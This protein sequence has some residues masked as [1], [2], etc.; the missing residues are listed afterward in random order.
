[1]SCFSAS[2]P[3]S[4]SRIGRWLGLASLAAMALGSASVSAQTLVTWNGGGADGNWSTTG[5]WADGIAP[6]T[7]G[8]FALTFSGSVRTTST[9]NVGAAPSSITLSTLTFANN[10]TNATSAFALNGTGARTLTIVPNGLIQTADNGSGSLI[11]DNI[12]NN[13]GLVVGGTTTFSMGT[14]HR[15]NVNGAVTGTGSLIKT[16]AGELAFQSGAPPSVFDSFQIDAGTLTLNNQTVQN[17]LV[18]KPVVANGGRINVGTGTTGFSVSANGSF[19]WRPY[20]GQSSTSTALNFNTPTATGSN[21]VITLNQGPGGSSAVAGRIQDNLT[22]PVAINIASGG[23]TLTFTLS[24]SNSFSGGTTVTTGSLIVANANALGNGGLTV[25][26]SGVLIDGVNAVVNGGLAGSAAGV[27]ASRAGASTLT[28]NTAT[29]S[30]YAGAL[31]NGAG[32]LTFVKSGSGLLTLSG[33]SNYTGTTTISGGTL[34]VNGSLGA[35]AVSV[36]DAAWLQG[37]GTIGGSI[38]VQGTLSPGNSPGVLTLGSVVLGGS[39]TSLIEIDGLTR[40]L[41]HDGVNIT[42]TSNSLTYGG[43]LSLNFGSLSPDNTT[44]DIF[45]FTG[46]YLGNYTTVTS[47]GAYVGTW[48]NLGGSGTF[49]LVSGGQTLTFSPSTGDIVVV[50]EPAAVALAGMGLALAGWAAAR[51]RRRT[52][53]DL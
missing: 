5:N 52:P 33:S 18:G 28:V 39:S 13:L 49:Q 53:R 36:A 26:T 10:G 6:T 37:T 50:P 45:N 3:G 20:S 12:Q 15:L 38:D 34:A 30:T 48:T 32:T 16:G 31:Q 2:F 44:Y 46:G 29:T 8:T 47:T 40:G 1:M 9:N 19:E 17:A 4:R 35:T 51:R 11:T 21:V 23:S 41:Q 22:T 7:T 27:I 24:G 42:G 14:L 25:N 43:L